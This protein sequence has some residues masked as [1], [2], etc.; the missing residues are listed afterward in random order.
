M[1]NKK[2]A[3]LDGTENGFEIIKQ[4][5]DNEICSV[6]LLIS[7]SVHGWCEFSTQPFY[8]QLLEYLRSLETQ[9]STDSPAEEQD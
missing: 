7:L 8:H 4:Y 5:A 9:D 1:E 3:P 2:S 6:G